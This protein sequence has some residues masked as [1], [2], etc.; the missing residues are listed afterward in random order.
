MLT[1]RWSRAPQTLHGSALAT[2]LSD[3]PLNSTDRQLLANVFIPVVQRNCYF[4]VKDWNSHTESVW[5]SQYVFQNK[6]FLP[7]AIREKELMGIILSKDR[8]TEVS[9]ITDADGDAFDFKGPRVKLK[10][11]KTTFKS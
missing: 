9:G 6:F 4:F 2:R 8:L 11:A 3:V 10:C 5:N 1:Y 7:R